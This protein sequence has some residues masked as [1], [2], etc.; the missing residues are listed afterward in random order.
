MSPS[1]SDRQLEV[2]CNGEFGK[3]WATLF[4][5]ALYEIY[6]LAAKAR[7]AAAASNSGDPKARNNSP[8]PPAAASS[9]SSLLRVA[10]LDDTRGVST[11]AMLSILSSSRNRKIASQLDR[12]VYI[13]APVSEKCVR[14]SGVRVI[15]CF[16]V[17]ICNHEAND[18]V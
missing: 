3:R 13:R 14:A 8:S 6:R 11:E 2:I 12:V 1:V 5:P 18:P 17:W 9:S 16:H 15:A 7:A 10:L 4:R